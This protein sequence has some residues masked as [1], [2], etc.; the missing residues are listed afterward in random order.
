MANACQ[1]VLEWLSGG[2]LGKVIIFSSVWV[3]GQP[4]EGNCVRSGQ[5]KGKERNCINVGLLSV[6]D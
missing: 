2:W 4:E 5:W 6:E 1:G 3:C